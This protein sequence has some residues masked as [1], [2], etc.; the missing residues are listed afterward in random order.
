MVDGPAGIRDAG[1]SDGKD[2]EEHGRRSVALEEPGAD[3]TRSRPDE[4]CTQQTYCGT[5]GHTVLLSKSL[6]RTDIPWDGGTTPC[7]SPSV[8]PAENRHTMGTKGP[9]RAPLQVLNPAENRHTMGTE[10]PHPASLQVLNPAQNRHT[11]GTE[12]PHP[13]PLQVLNPAENRYH[14]D[15]GTTLCSSPSVEPCREQTYHGTEGPH[16]APLQVLN[17]VL[18]TREMCEVTQL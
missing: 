13:A 10:G 16:P 17:P 9:H 12:G 8:E 4:P 14:G 7:S 11:M 5:E 18:N 2:D 3:Q 1:Q 6:Q 15:R